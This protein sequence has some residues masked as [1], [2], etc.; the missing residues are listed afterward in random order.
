MVSEVKGD[1]W[2]LI[3]QSSLFLVQFGVFCEANLDD[4]LAFDPSSS[5]FC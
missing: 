3:L 1:S 4:V 5:L 2:W